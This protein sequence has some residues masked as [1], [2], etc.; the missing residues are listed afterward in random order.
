MA[1]SDI[2]PGK[3]RICVKWITRGGKRIYASSYGLQAFCF[4]VDA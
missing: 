1:P 3:K 2:P 4:L